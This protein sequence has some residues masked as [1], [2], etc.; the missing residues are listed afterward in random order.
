MNLELEKKVK[1]AESLRKKPGLLM[2]MFMEADY[3][4][5][6][7][8]YCEVARECENV[9]D[10]VKFYREAAT[11][12]LMK[13]SEYNSYRASECYKKLFDI[14]EGVDPA[15]AIGYYALYAEC[16]EKA[17]KF[18][19]AGQ[20]YMKIAETIQKTDEKRA[21]DIY[22]RAHETYKRDASCPYHAKEAVQKC[23]TLQLKNRELADAIRSFD[24]LDTKYS[25]LS[26][27]ILC[28]LQGENDFEDDLDKEEGMVIM[29]LLNRETEE[30]IDILENFRKDNYL[31]EHT[32]LVFDIAIERLRPENDIC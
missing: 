26:K 9:E 25:K 28:F 32:S 30:C 8:L 29:A 14:L 31:P 22:K 15:Q 20:A 2:S 19:M 27:Q 21:I 13:N 16:Q 23:L 18:L 6:G 17:E 12:F 5:S 11:T 1:Q 10:R 4:G 3:I 24:T 7:E